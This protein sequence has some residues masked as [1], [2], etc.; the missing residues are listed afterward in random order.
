MMISNDVLVW[1]IEGVG[2]MKKRYDVCKGERKEALLTNF[3]QNLVQR[4]HFRN[5]DNLKNFL[6]SFKLLIKFK[7]L[8]LRKDCKLS[9][10]Y[11]YVGETLQKTN[12]DGF[13]VKN[14]DMKRSQRQRQKGKWKDQ[15]QDQDQDH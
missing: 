5:S 1:D 9:R 7:V 14:D 6:K 8:T 11:K 2:R 10:K 12:Q 13:M 3:R 15:D 4:M